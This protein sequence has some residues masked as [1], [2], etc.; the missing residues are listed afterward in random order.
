MVIRDSEFSNIVAIPDVLETGP[1]GKQRGYARSGKPLDV[2]LAAAVRGM[3]ATPER[4]EDED[5]YE[6]KEEEEDEEDE[7]E[8]GDDGEDRSGEEDE[9]EDSDE[10]ELNEDDIV[11]AAPLTGLEAIDPALRNQL[12]VTAG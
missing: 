4:E 9:G 12:E 7:D 2:G 1:R 11:G 8:E 10:D 5:D 6:V 3:A